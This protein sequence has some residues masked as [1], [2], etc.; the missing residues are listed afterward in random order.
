MKPT[1]I[2]GIIA[3]VAIVAILIIVA[4]FLGVIHIPG[5]VIPELGD[6]GELSPDDE[7]APPGAIYCDF[8]DM[9][10]LDMIETVTGKD[11]DNAVGVSFVRALNM[12][13]CGSDDETAIN[14]AAYYRTL[15]SNWYISD[16]A[17]ASG[18]GWTAYRIV[19][20]NSADPS[21]ATLVRAVM[22]GEGT[23]VKMAY[24]YDTITIVSDGPVVTYGAF[25][26]WVA[27]S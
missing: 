7:E 12:Q 25:M 21:S 17:V 8:T 14:I 18:G 10:I 9:Q 3:A 19:W 15:Y 5:V 11:L 13:A 24:G 27:S 6:N 20:L 2:I 23:T 16:D 22:I 1:W 26:I 4:M